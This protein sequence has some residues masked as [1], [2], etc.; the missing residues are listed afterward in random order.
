MSDIEIAQ[1]KVDISMK[2][3]KQHLNM[4]FINLLILFP[5]IWFVINHPSQWYNAITVGGLLAT[6]GFTYL[7]LSFE[8]SDLRFYKT[9]LN[10]SKWNDEDE[11]ESLKYIIGLNKSMCFK[12]GDNK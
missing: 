8:L 5:N 11:K 2:A 12:V 6:L 1:F 10:R 9:C 3:Y 7:N 4:F